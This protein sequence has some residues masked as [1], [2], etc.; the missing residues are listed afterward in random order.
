MDAGLISSLVMLV[1][2]LFFFGL[3]AALIIAV[4]RW[5]NRKDRK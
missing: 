4:I 5:L 3:F 2:M 1:L